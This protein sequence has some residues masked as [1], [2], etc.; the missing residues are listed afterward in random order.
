MD[1]LH[2]RGIDKNCPRTWVKKD[3]GMSRVVLCTEEQLIALFKTCDINQDGRLSKEE[4]K[5]IF[6]KLGSHFASWRVYRAL[7]HADTN[8]DGYIS[9]EEFSDLVRYILTRCDYR[10]K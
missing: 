3:R 10:F 5:N 9:E 6:N 8:G 1:L 4:L 7:H 2:H